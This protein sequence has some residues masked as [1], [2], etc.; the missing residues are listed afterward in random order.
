MPRRS[1][2]ATSLPWCWRRSPSRDSLVAGIGLCGVVAMSVAAR[3]RELAIRIALGAS[4]GGIRRLVLR[5]AGVIVAI[6]TALGAVGAAAG[7]SLLRNQLVGVS[8]TDTQ[9]WV[10]MVVILAAAG[11]TAAWLPAR[12]A[13]RVDP[14][15]ALRQE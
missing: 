8:S 14:I 7:T 1:R 12:R 13:G 6:G 9:T 10:A 2:L 5:E 4:G 11:L 15:E 3:T